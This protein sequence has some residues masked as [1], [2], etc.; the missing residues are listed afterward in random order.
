M[1]EK[2]KRNVTGKRKPMPLSLMVIFSDKYRNKTE[3]KE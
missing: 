1:P 2:K 3:V